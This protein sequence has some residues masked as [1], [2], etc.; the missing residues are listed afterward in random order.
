M[1][2]RPLLK[3]LNNNAFLLN[4]K[5]F[6]SCLVDNEARTN[7]GAERAFIFLKVLIFWRT[8][9]SLW[10]KLA[11]ALRNGYTLG[12]SKGVQFF[13]LASL[14]AKLSNFKP[15]L[16]KEP[17]SLKNYVKFFKRTHL[18]DLYLFW[19]LYYY[20]SLIGKFYS[21]SFLIWAKLMTILNC[22]S[23]FV[24]NLTNLKNIYKFRDLYS[25]AVYLGG[26]D[27]AFCHFSNFFNIGALLGSLK[28]SALFS[29]AS[30]YTGLE[31]CL[32]HFGLI[33]DIGVTSVRLS[34]QKK[35]APFFFVAHYEHGA[36][37]FLGRKK[38]RFFAKK[39]MLLSI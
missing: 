6:I 11:K 15:T 23:K 36:R 16:T 27:N 21:V 32:D 13:F 8:F 28:K 1:A 33:F 26:L 9:I 24:K 4:F 34:K 19:N 12:F 10:N 2:K 3:L 29:L 37:G 25:A 17:H 14:L 30:Y 22:S 5:A 38:R 39:N 20:S 31:K 35:Y 7:N 18:I